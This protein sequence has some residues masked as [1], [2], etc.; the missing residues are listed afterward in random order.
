M[1]VYHFIQ[2]WNSRKKS[3]IQLDRGAFALSIYINNIIWEKYLLR[4]L[5]EKQKMLLLQHKFHDV[6]PFAPIF[7]N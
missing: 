6:Q 2:K 7:H 3:N 5:D 1:F 4:K